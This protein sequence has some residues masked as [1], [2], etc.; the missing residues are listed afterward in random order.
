VSPRIERF[1]GRG[2]R[3]VRA[4][5]KHLAWNDPRF[6]AVPATIGLTSPSF[7]DG[8]RMPERFAG[9]GVGQNI[10][11]PLDWQ[12]VPAETRELVLVMQDPDAPLPR[13]VVHLV[14]VGLDPRRAGLGAGELSPTL[15]NG[16]RYGTGSFGRVGYAGPRPVRGHGPHRY[17]FQLFAAREPLV[18]ESAP[19]LQVVLSQLSGSVL[20]RG[21]LT[22]I[23]ERP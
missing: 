14:V 9:A 4:G 6:A 20:A 23:F 5:D 22:G 13:P 8:E 16:L 17:I 15:A 2:L 21:R 1:I 7:A 11:P 19:K 3:S 12:D 18:L 10:S